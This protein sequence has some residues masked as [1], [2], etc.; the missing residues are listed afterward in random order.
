MIPLFM[1]RLA[2]HTS[3]GLC[4]RAFTRLMPV[5]AIR[6]GA[7]ARGVPR[8]NPWPTPKDGVSLSARGRVETGEM[9][10]VAPAKG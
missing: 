2:A 6:S 10:P 4:P 3:S 1:A 5:M 8:G 9:E 7:S